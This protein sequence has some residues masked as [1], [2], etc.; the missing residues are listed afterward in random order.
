VIG[1]WLGWRE[2]QRNH[3]AV[4]GLKRGLGTLGFEALSLENLR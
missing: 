3:G 2:G 1:S 4:S